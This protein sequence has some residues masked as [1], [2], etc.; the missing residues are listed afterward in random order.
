M[1]LLVLHALRDLCTGTDVFDLGGQW[2]GKTQVHLLKLAKELGVETYEQ[3]EQGSS[4]A[5]LSDKKLRKFKGTIPRVNI[6]ALLELHF[7]IK[8]LNDMAASVN[9]EDPSLTPNAV[10]WDQQTL[11][12]LVEK[13]TRST[14]CVE[15]FEI[16][17]RICFGCE[18]KDMSLLYFLWY[19]KCAGSVDAMIETKDGGQEFKFVGGAYQ[20]SQK[21]AELIGSSK[22]IFNSPVRAIEQE[23]GS[24]VRIVTANGKEI[25]AKYVVVALPPHLAA[26][27]QYS[28]TLPIK[29]LR[30]M[31]NHLP[32]LMNQ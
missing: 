14:L 7:L 21:L 27:F 4:F 12:Y 13:K 20:I 16:A 29:R 3:Y 30:L 5:R 2:A 22:F 9:V 26:T 15:L 28:P 23:E 6:F 31:Q 8:G 25:L 32:G 18:I 10:E 17:T 19:V 1:R 24:G 11:Q